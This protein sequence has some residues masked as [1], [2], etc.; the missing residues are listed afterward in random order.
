MLRRSSFALIRI[1]LIIT[2]NAWVIDKASSQVNYIADNCSACNSRNISALNSAMNLSE[3]VVGI[4]SSSHVIGFHA[5][6]VAP[7]GGV[8]SMGKNWYPLRPEKQILRG[9]LK[10]FEIY[11][12]LGDEM[13]WNLYILPDPEYE[14]LVLEAVPYQFEHT[15][16]KLG[17]G[18]E[19]FGLDIG[20]GV[21]ND[22]WH[23]MTINGKK[24][25]LIEGEITPDE[26][27]YNNP[28]FPKT[29]RSPLI[30]RKI[31]LY[32]PH[33]REENHGNRP[34]IHP[35]E[36]I[37]WRDLDG[38]YYLMLILD[39]SNRFDDPEDFKFGNLNIAGT[40]VN[41]PI[42]N[43]WTP[44]AT[45]KGLSGSFKIA[46]EVRP[47]GDFQMYQINLEAK[48]QLNSK[49]QSDIDDGTEHSIMYK[50]KKVLT[51]TEPKITDDQIGVTFENVC[52]NQQKNLLQGYIVITTA[53]GNGE[54]KEGYALFRVDKT[55]IDAGAQ[56]VKQWQYKSGSGSWKNLS[57]DRDNTSIQEM[58]ISDYKG[59]GMVDGII[60]FDGNGKSDI[61]KT[62][63]K[64]WYVSYDGTSPWQKINNSNVQIK[65]MRFG[66]FDGDKKTDIFTID[67]KTN[68]W[69]LS[70]GGT[71]SWERINSSIH[72]LSKL[73][74]GDFNGDGKTDVFGCEL[75]NTKFRVQFGGNAGE[76]T[77]FGR[78]L[79]PLTF[80]KMSKTFPVDQLRFG[81]FNGDGK[82]D[83]FSYYEKFWWVSWGGKTIW[84][85]LRN[86]QIRYPIAQ[87]LFGNF[88]QGS[89]STDILYLSNTSW[90]YSFNGKTAWNSIPNSDADVLTISFGDFD[91]NGVMDAFR[92]KN[93]SI[94]L[95]K[96]VAKINPL[97]VGPAY[98]L[99]YS[100]NSLKRANLNGKSVL[101][102][103]MELRPIQDGD[104]TPKRVTR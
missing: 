92:A 57:L 85:K 22:E 46:F 14:S 7:K 17:L 83:V 43:N 37:W 32:G 95:P 42:P 72:P 69:K 75:S 50:G 13:D 98:K 30:D 54:G 91:G 68:E 66:D 99:S 73:R 67:P 1:V 79:Y 103:D 5:A 16:S 65:D 62:K 93:S 40:D 9:T 74:V 64:D 33:I 44:W 48:H 10:K 84:E 55:Q 58:L 87:L 49:S 71:G 28:W 3:G 77:D 26:K 63:G 25:V 86:D 59:Y 29:G 41:I 89:K 81:D 94:E 31:C 100:K 15:A 8:I 23:T 60:D 4:N 39:D 96:A 51:I 80:S 12:G 104:F 47:G 36:Q 6:Y 88:D 18:S 97:S 53:V 35:C 52:F 45:E 70:K 82:T 20:L 90:N 61:F 78:P 2:G 19:T 24:R 76:W 101:A 34:E 21:M 27:F 56:I 102:M 11:D 38:S